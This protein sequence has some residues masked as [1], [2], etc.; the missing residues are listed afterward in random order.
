MRPYLVLCAVVLIA[1]A[2]FGQQPVPPRIYSPC[3][4]GCGPYVPLITTPMVSLQTVSPNPVGATN[5]TTGLIA[6]AT[7][8]TLSQIQGSTSSE[9]TEAVWYQGGDAPLMTSRIHLLREPIGHEARPMHEVHGAGEENRG[10]WLYFSGSDHTASAAAAS[11][12]AKGFKKAAHVYTNDDVERQ[13]QTNGTVKHGGK[14]EK[15]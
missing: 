3:L 9:Y 6:G 4:Y 10:G 8:S 2:A 11:G 13:N 5:A 7:N 15:M 12:A 1:V 14:T